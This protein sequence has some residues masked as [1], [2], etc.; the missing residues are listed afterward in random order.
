MDP[1][2]LVLFIGVATT[3]HERCQEEKEIIAKTPFF[4]EANF[5]AIFGQPKSKKFN[6]IL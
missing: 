3:S 6:A 4:Y 5:S 1:T 2:R